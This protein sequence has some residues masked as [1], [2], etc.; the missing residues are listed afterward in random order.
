MR[1]G[2]SS[3]RNRAYEPDVIIIGADII[4]GMPPHIIMHGMPMFIMDCIMVMRSFIMSICAMSIGIIFIIMPSLVISQV[5]RH[6]IGAIMPFM[7]F[8]PII[9]IGIIIGMP[10]PIIGFMPIMGFIIGFIMPIMFIMGFMP[11]MFIMGFIIPF[12][13]PCGIAFIIGFIPMLWFIAFII[14]MATSYVVA[15]SAQGYREGE[16]EMALPVHSTLF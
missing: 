12:I 3:T 7:P 5:M 14:L 8:M 11:I 16:R 9:G 4:I 1:S 15:R 6:I 13:I 10:M 2:L